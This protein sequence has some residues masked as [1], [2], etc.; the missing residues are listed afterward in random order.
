MARI[1]IR[2]FVA[3][4]GRAFWQPTKRMR[5]L[6][7]E[8]VPLG[9]DGPEAWARAHKLNEQWERTRKGEAP[10]PQYCYAPHTLGSIFA[11]Y[12]QM[13]AW[14]NKAKATRFEWERRTWPHIEPIF[15][16]VHVRTVTIEDCDAFYAALIETQPLREAHRVMKILRAMFQVAITFE[17][18]SHNPTA[19]IRNKA[20]APRSARWVEG[21]PFA[22]LRAPGGLAIAAWRV[23]SRLPGT[24][25]S[26]QWTFGPLRL[27]MPAMKRLGRTLRSGEKKRMRLRSARFHGAHSG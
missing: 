18:I 26:R 20:P 11:R 17:E 25:N 21:E 6:G 13:H 2:Y 15:A 24:P 4:G 5:R 22:L 14:R 19:G 8:S 12:R 7:F 27:P 1:K 3:K 10:P 23:L 9:L 16:D